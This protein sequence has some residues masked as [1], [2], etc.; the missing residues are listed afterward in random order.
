MK[1]VLAMEVKQNGANY[2]ER[3]LGINCDC[4]CAQMVCPQVVCP[5]INPGCPGTS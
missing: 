2:E 3:G 5:T 1:G 4:G